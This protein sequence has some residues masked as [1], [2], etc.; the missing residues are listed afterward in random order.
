MQNPLIPILLSALLLALAVFIIAAVVAQ[1]MQ[2]QESLIRNRLM[3]LKNKALDV[4][5]DDVRNRL[6]E[7]KETFIAQVEPIANRYFGSNNRMR[8]EWKLLLNEAGQS[9]NDT[10]VKRMITVQVAL[11]ALFGILG[12]FL[13]AASGKVAFG[14]ILGACAGTAGWMLP[15]MKIRGKA[16]ARKSEI[17]FALPD[18]LD[19]MVVCVEAGLSLDA[20]IQRVAEETERMSPEVSTEFKRLNKELNAGIPRMEAFQNMGFRAG[21]DELKSL[22]ALIV[23]ADKM[24]TSIADTLRIYANDVR[25]KRRQKAEELAAK[26]SIKMTFPLV[27]FIFPPLFIVLM[28]PMVIT[29]LGTFF[30]KGGGISPHPPH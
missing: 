22:C 6:A 27:F 30:G 9:D 3:R 10:A 13:G 4:P 29:A 1:A 2:P 16:S 11:A 26:A 14:T 15:K 21:V 19:L 7:I 28:G 20:T 5:K 17:R 8:Q 12:F 24:G 23:Q 25:V 18:I